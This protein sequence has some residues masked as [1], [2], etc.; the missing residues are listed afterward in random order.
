MSTLQLHK[1]I[2]LLGTF[3]VGKTSLVR[4]FVYDKYEDTYKSTIGVKVSQ[5]RLAPLENS[6]REMVQFTF[7]V[8]DIEGVE[9]ATPQVT[10]Y[11]TGA[12]GFLLVGDLTRVETLEALPAI[13]GFA[14]KIAPPAPLVLAGN[15]TDLIA[16]GSEAAAVLAEVAD[17]LAAPF[18]L[19]SAKDGR[20]VE[21][22]FTE[23]GLLI[24][25]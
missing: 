16:D 13:A 19:T 23:L 8:W 11:L 2:C 25:E 18:L 24:A 22:C 1:K 5:K 4:R 9:K 15:K 21:E 7:L 6:R 20:N 12:H 3:G 17:R 10:N 14:R